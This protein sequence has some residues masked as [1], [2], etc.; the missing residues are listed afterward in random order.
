MGALLVRVIFGG[1][2]TRS[3]SLQP[4]PSL[5]EQGMC[6]DTRESRHHFDNS[7]SLAH[8]YL[9]ALFAALFVS[10][11]A[12]H[13]NEVLF[14]FCF[15]FCWFFLISIFFPISTFYSFPFSSHF[16]FSIEKKQPPA[17]VQTGADP[18]EEAGEGVLTRAGHRP[19]HR[20]GF[21]LLP[22]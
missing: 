5:L 3:P 9:M 2:P 12:I 6:S 21:A 17:I 20:A 8:L 16:Q 7:I 4:S 22:K 15:K 19:C 18:Q 10:F 1:V 11:M 14:F 13:L